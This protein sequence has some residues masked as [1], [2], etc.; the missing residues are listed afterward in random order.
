M[1]QQ[2]LTR[3]MVRRAGQPES[4]KNFSFSGVCPGS[5]CQL[6]RFL[7]IGLDAAEQMSIP[8]DILALVPGD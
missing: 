8:S 1:V 6:R 2:V 3:L 5:N 4:I 7:I